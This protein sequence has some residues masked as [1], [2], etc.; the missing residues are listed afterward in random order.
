MLG[1]PRT[2]NEIFEAGD[3]VYIFRVDKTSKGVARHRQNKGEW[4]GPGVVVGKEGPSYWVSRGGRCVLC[5]AEHLRPAE[6][7]EL[8]TAFQT[9]AV[10]EDLMGLALRLDDSEDEEA[11]A[12]AT[13]PVYP[14]RLVNYDTVPERRV[15][16]KGTVRICSPWRRGTRSSPSTSTTCA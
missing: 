14:K 8:G 16:E 11:F 3:Y 12:D 5:A 9:R 10:K 4:I 1:R 2:N 15:R 13:A 6:S 7:E